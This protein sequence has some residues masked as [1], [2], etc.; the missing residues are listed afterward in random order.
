MVALDGVILAVT[1]TY[2]HL[3]SEEPK[4][5]VL[6]DPDSL[7]AGSQELTVYVVEDDSSVSPT[8]GSLPG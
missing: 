2:G 5:S 4:F 6:L 7:R 1:E 8:A 3:P